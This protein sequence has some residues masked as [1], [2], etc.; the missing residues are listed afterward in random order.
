MIRHNLRQI[1]QANQSARYM[2]QIFSSQL[3]SHFKVSQANEK[4]GAYVV[5]LTT[6]PRD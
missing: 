1:D 4:Y 2:I 3:E 6:K 5:T